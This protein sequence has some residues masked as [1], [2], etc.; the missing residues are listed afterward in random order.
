MCE[1]ITRVF[2]CGC[3]KTSTV[4]T[5][6]YVG[7]KGHKVVDSGKIETQGL[8]CHECF[9]TIQ[10]GSEAWEGDEED[11]EEEEEEEK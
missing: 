5:C 10:C 3:K 6:G 11:D 1:Q 4:K 8:K 2:T 7:Q 9:I